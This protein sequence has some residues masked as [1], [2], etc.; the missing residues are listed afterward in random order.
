[1]NS[2]GITKK[3]KNYYFNVIDDPDNDQIAMYD[4]WEGIELDYDD[5]DQ[6][7]NW[8]SNLQQERSQ[9]GIL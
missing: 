9:R 5:I 7:I 1:M 6:L 8:L 4:E 3:Y 2:M